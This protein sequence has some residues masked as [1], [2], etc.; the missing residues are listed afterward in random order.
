MT[1]FTFSMTDAD[2]QEGIKSIGQRQRSI[3]VDVQK[4]VVSIVHNWATDGAVNVCA[5]RMTQLLAQI[6]PSHKQKLVNWCNEICSFMLDEDKAG[7][8]VL[9][10]DGNVTT[11]DAAGF[12][13]AKALNLFDFT[14]DAP[15]KAFD[16]KAKFAQLIAAAEKRSA[17][18]DATKRNAEDD[19]PAELVAS[20]KAL[21]AALPAVEPAH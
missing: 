2:V 4:L 10:Y 19:I 8:E 13:K 18:T 21:L 7:N 11:I 17:V 3:R 20:A 15:P 9:K 12:A 6:D 1:K 5:Q 16:F 14:P